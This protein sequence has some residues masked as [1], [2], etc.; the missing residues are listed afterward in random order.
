MENPLKYLLWSDIGFTCLLMINVIILSIIVAPGEAFV[1]YEGVIGLVI[2]LVILTYSILFLVWIYRVHKD[3]QS[4]DSSY[5]ISPGRAL[6]QILIPI[7]NL[8]GLWNV[9]STMA[10]YFKEDEPTYEEGRKVGKVI[11][12]YYSLFFITTIVNNSLL[13]GDSE[14]VVW[15]LSYIGDIALLVTYILIIKSVSKGLS[16]LVEHQAE[17]QGDEHEAQN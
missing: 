1:T 14:L 12:Y 16:N 15:F 7:Y 11:P 13:V 17:V 6:A 9:Y 5:R 8:Y 2:T 4:L 10:D 3:L